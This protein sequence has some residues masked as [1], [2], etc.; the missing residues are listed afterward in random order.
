MSRPSG[1][2]LWG[3]EVGEGEGP[4]GPVRRF[5]R[6]PPS[7]PAVLDAT[8]DRWPD[9]VH[10]VRGTER[11]TFAE[12]GAA[13]E[14]AARQLLEHGV[15][16]GD[17]VGILAANGPR[18]IAT[19]WAC[20]RVGAIAVPLNWSWRAPQVRS[21][22]DDC[23]PTVVAV[24]RAHAPLVPDDLT[25]DVE[26][27]TAGH[28]AGALPAADDAGE[29]DGTTEA[30]PCL[31]IYTSGTTGRPKGATFTHGA[32]VASAQNALVKGRRL[33]DELP[34]DAR[35]PVGLLSYPV[36]HIAGVMNVV[37]STAVG[38]VLVFGSPRFDPVEV[39]RLIERE[40]VVAW[41]AV[42]TMVQRAVEALGDDPVDVTSL[43]AITLG[44]AAMPPGLVHEVAR[45]FPSVRGH[46]ANAYGM[47]ETGGTVALASGSEAAEDPTCVG[48]PMSVAEI[49]IDG[50]DGSGRG[51]IV[52][53]TPSAMLGYWQS[54]DSPVDADG[55]VHTGDVGYLDDDG[56]LHV[57]DR[58]RDVIIRGGENISP[59]AV[60][61]AILHHPRVHEACVVSV[62]DPDF[63]EAVAAIVVTDD[64]QLPV[65]ELA[66]HA[67]AR[68][69][70][71]EVPARWWIRR[72]PL[73]RGTLDKLLRRTLRDEFLAHETSTATTEV[74]R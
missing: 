39:L 19:L 74:G 9:R 16:P 20:W 26:D 3:R 32:V 17:R 27:T 57:V 23:R 51:E 7:L 73:A 49:A 69:A 35:A 55:W 40:R 33:P 54:D 6:R 22:I 68:L 58:I 42:P 25:L 14:R 21:A 64:P 31:I 34:D 30:S 67:R 10:L 2:S 18:W 43:R 38:G 47:T 48:R 12:H 29:A 65:E 61:D 44:G 66:E 4:H 62:P 60:E 52:V 28:G 37:I 53:R 45:R 46:V 71:F 59:T 8:I 13:V 24:D 72:E 15:R 11:I 70:T 5:L 63:G 50:A 41:G 36:F 56:R 1:G